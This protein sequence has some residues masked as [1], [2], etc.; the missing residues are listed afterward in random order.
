MAEYLRQHWE[1]RYEGMS[2]ADRGGGT[3][4]AYLPD[5]LDGWNLDL[6]G[7][8]AADI[9]D[10]EAAIQ[11]LD[12]PGAGLVSLDGLARYLLRAESVASSRIE[13][14]HVSA[15]RLLQAEAAIAD[16][17]EQADRMAAEV[18]S[19]IRATETAIDIGSGDLPLDLPMLLEIHNVLMQG[20]PDPGVGGR[21]R[22]QQNWIGGSNFNPLRAE[23]I[24]P[25]PD[26][27]QAL[28]DDLCL[29]IDGDQ[30]SPVTQ[31]ALAHAQFETIHPFMDGNGRTGRALIPMVLRRRGLTGRSVPPISLVLAGRSRDYVAGLTAFRHTSQSDSRER[32]V[33]AH[34][35]LRTFASATIA[36]CAEA[37]RFGDRIEELHADW[38]TRLGR[39]RSDSSAIAL[40]AVLPGVPVL[41][42]ETA[43]RLIDRSWVRT[44]DGV[45]RLVE[46]GILTQR[47]TGRRRDR[48]FEAPDVVAMF[49]AFEH[50]LAAT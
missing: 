38:R 22:D 50:R 17:G 24:P 28:L 21:L 34:E 40:L 44:N 37:R 12:D 2:R 6:P 8:L 23:F 3:Y 30:H 47:N 35:W 4:H 15:R 1:A 10:A 7:D 33:A 36:A 41:T 13:G 18:L 48:I 26:R 20:S 49:T 5:L 19:N 39:I 31:A 25:P 32:S 29:Y 27:L 46:A 11:R 45:G 9:A 43:R 42:V 16:G 14:V